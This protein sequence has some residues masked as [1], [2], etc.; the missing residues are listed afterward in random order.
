MQGPNA[1]A[2]EFNSDQD[3]AVSGRAMEL[4]AVEQNPCEVYPRVPGIECNLFQLPSPNRSRAL[5]QLKTYLDTYKARFLGYQANQDLH[6][7]DL[8]QYLDYHI[9]NIGDPFKSGNFN[10][11]CKW[12]ERSVLDYYAR[13]WKAPLPH[14][15]KNPDSYWGY[16]LSM[17]STEGNMYAFWNG[18]DYL[19]GKQMMHDPDKNALAYVDAQPGDNPNQY[20]PIAFY[21][22]DSHYSI[23]KLLIVLGIKSVEVKSNPDGSISL[24]ALAALVDE[25]ASKGHPVLVNLNYGTTFKGAY[26]DVKGVHD[27]LKPILEKHGLYSRRVC[28]DGGRCVVRNGFWLHVDGALGAAYMPYIKIAQE[29]SMF[30]ESGPE[31][32][33]RQPVHSISMSGHK[34]IGAPWPCGVYM[35]RTKLQMRPPGN[36]EYIGSADTPFAGSRNGFSS[37]ILWDYLSRTTQADRIKK[38]VD[39]MKLAAHAQALLATVTRRVEPKDLWVG[40]SRLS[41]TIHFRRPVQKIV[42]KFSLSNDTLTLNGKRRDYSHIFIMEHVTLELLREL[43]NDLTRDDAYQR[44]GEMAAEATAAAYSGPQPLIEIPFSGRGFE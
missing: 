3:Q 33:F 2:T 39:L 6:F 17:G 13:L 15:P 31:F 26:D 11:N 28:Y 9:N 32:D 37:M 42:E 12:I 1:T 22:E 10:M 7:E 27:R 4:S 5:A 19:S 43:A 18:R 44:P 35:T 34:W 40:R 8:K 41:L 25:Y 21:S 30:P 24:N 20:I 16:V 36:P 38:A 14:D 29:R 23:L